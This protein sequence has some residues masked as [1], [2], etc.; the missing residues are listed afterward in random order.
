MIDIGSAIE[1][2]AGTGKI[3]G[4]EIVDQDE[5][6]V[7][8]YGCRRLGCKAGEQDDGKDESKLV[9]GLILGKPSALLNSNPTRTV[10]RADRSLGFG[11]KA[12]REGGWKINRPRSWG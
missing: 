6:K 4:T 9:H 5:K 10:L 11:P 2:A 12:A 7:R 1:L 8:F 3:P